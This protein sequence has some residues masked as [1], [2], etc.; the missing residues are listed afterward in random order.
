MTRLTSHFTLEAMSASQTAARLGM[1]NKVPMSL[2]GNIK[3]TALWLEVLRD[4][5]SAHFGKECLI[6][7]Y[8]VYRSPEVNKA[9]G[10]SKNSAHMQGLAADIFVDLCSPAELQ[11][12]IY[13][14]MQD[15]LYDQCIE[16]FGQ[17][18]HI[19]LK[20]ASYGFPRGELLKAEKIRGFA[21]LKTVYKRVIV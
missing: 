2:M 21:G 5:L 20:P 1:D 7:V 9:V 19:G 17:W 6:F 10:G 13:A 16:E 12:L 18:V 15:K 11:K 8:S 4:R 3:Y 14:L